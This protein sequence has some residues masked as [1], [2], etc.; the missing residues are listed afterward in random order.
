MQPESKELVDKNMK[1]MLG[2]GVLE[3]RVGKISRQSFPVV[4]L[5]RR[6]DALIKTG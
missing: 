5:Q 3:T 2:R 6:F 1:T 4:C